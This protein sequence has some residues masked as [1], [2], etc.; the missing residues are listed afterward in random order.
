MPGQAKPK[1]EAK[2]TSRPPAEAGSRLV[3][4]RTFNASLDGN[5]RRAIDLREGAVLAA[6]AFKVL[7][8]TAVAGNLR[9]GTSR[10]R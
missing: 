1:Q 8:H 2:G 5:T 6:E 10:Q 4:P 9:A 7:I 3:A